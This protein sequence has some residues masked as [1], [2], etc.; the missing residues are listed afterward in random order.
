MTALVLALLGCTGEETDPP[1][2][3]LPTDTGDTDE[4]E[5][6]D[7]GVF[8][9]DN[10]GGNALGNDVPDDTIIITQTGTWNLSGNPYDALVGTLS[11]RELVNG[12]DPPTG[13]TALALECDALFGLQGTR[14]TDPTGCPSCDHVWDVQFTLSPDSLTDTDACN[15]PDLPQDGE[16]WRLGY[17]SGTNTIWFN[18]YGTGVWVA[19]WGALQNGDTVV[20]EWS[21]ELAIDIPEPEEDE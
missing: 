13:D 16:T 20:Y 17:A 21:R 1:T 8:R 10:T 19:W 6:V 2:P 18:F 7:T 15:D 12:F 4:V 11:S 3:E 5:W 9:P 14:V